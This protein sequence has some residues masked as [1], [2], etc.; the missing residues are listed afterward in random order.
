MLVLVKGGEFGIGPQ[1]SA[2]NDMYLGVAHDLEKKCW[3]LHGTKFR[4]AA[5]LYDLWLYYPVNA[6][7]EA[8]PAALVT[9]VDLP[10]SHPVLSDWAHFYLPTWP[11]QEAEAAVNVAWNPR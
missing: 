9:Q 7:C 4:L 11:R 1:V 2:W 8:T 10:S 3:T 6:D 5:H